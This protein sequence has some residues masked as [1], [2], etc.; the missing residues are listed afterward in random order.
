[1]QCRMCGYEFDETRVGGCAGCGNCADGKKAHCPNCGYGNPVVYEERDFEFIEKLKVKQI[2]TLANA[3]KT[4]IMKHDTKPVHKE[5]LS[6]NMDLFIQNL[7]DDYEYPEPFV[8]CCAKLRRYVSWNDDILQIHY[9]DYGRYIHASANGIVTYSGWISG[10]GNTVI[11]SHGGAYET[12]YGHNQE[13]RR[14]FQ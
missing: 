9:N 6:V 2:E 3:I 10:Y 7:P 14:G 4:G 13:A 11:L 12:L 1:M 5:N 8:K